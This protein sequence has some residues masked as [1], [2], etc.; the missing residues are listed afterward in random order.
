MIDA[1]PLFFED[2]RLVRDTISA[3]LGVTGPIDG[4]GQLLRHTIT[5]LKCDVAIARAQGK[6]MVIDNQLTLSAAIDRAEHLRS[7][8]DLYYN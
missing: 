3:T 1:S 7:I 6:A 5:E 8:Y 4:F 2:I